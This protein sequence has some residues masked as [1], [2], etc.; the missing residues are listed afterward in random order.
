M[1]PLIMLD[2]EVFF[3]ELS[4][5]FWVITH[6]FH[7]LPLRLGLYHRNFIVYCRNANFT[8]VPTLY[9]RMPCHYPCRALKEYWKI[10]DCFVILVDCCFFIVLVFSP[11][12]VLCCLFVLLLGIDYCCCCRICY[13]R[14]C[15]AFIWG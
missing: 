6:L 1:I 4:D 5:L 10:V 3:L 8:T 14:R 13:G 11:T 12:E 15:S 2:F 9:S 7:S